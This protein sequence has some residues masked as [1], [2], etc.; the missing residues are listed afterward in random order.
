V[1]IELDLLLDLSRVDLAPLIHDTGSGS[2]I[3]PNFGG[4]G[5]NSLDLHV[6]RPHLALPSIQKR[7]MCGLARGRRLLL[8]PGELPF[9]LE[10]QV[11]MAFAGHNGFQGLTD[12]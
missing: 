3:S 1:H 5:M 7:I 8:H 11:G 10:A 4:S 9:R 12:T 6:P 2:N